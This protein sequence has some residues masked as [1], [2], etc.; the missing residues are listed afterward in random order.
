MPSPTRAKTISTLVK[1]GRVTDLTDGIVRVQWDG[2]KPHEE[3]YTATRKNHFY[4]QFGPISG[5]D[6]TLFDTLKIERM[7]EYDS[8]SY[9]LEFSDFNITS[10]A[11]IG[12]TVKVYTNKIHSLYDTVQR[13]KHIRITVEGSRY[14]PEQRAEIGTLVIGTTMT[15]NVPIDWE[16]KDNEAP[17]NRSYRTRGGVTWAYC[18]GPE[19]RTLQGL[20]RGDVSEQQRRK[21]RT[22][23]RHSTDYSKTP[24]VFIQ[25]AGVY[26]AERII[27]CRYDEN[28][29]FDNQGWYYNPNSQ[30]W[31][32]V[33]DISLS[34]IEVV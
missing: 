4:A 27:L 17:N 3:E 6:L 18:E 21:L 32:P 26:D 24:I 10:P 28:T 1:T 14:F 9:N 13:E 7:S 23:L 12:T 5:S 15:L 22:K 16:W 2:Y 11:S 20:M 8:T 33:G 25:D 29:E 31:E 34:F 19:I 30:G